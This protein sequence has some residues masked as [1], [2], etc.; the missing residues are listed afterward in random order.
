VTLHL[1]HVLL[2]LA[3]LCSAVRTCVA[4]LPRA[5][6]ASYTPSIHGYSADL[7]VLIVLSVVLLAG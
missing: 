2:C 6:F 4:E 1:T 3:V 5:S 7:L